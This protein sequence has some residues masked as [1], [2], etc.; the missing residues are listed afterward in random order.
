MR[1]GLTCSNC[2]LSSH[3]SGCICREREREGGEGGREGGEG[4]ERGKRG[5][6]GGRNK[7]I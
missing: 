2:L 6:G 3:R 5:G 1:R 4:G 7:R